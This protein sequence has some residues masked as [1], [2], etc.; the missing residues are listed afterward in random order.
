[1]SHGEPRPQSEPRGRTRVEAVSVARALDEIIERR[2]LQR[3]YALYREIAR[4][5]GVHPTTVLRYH[6]GRLSTARGI[7]RARTLAL[8]QEVRHGRRLPFESRKPRRQ[9][10]ARIAADARIPTDELKETFEVVRRALGLRQH[11]FL[12]R[13]LA[14]RLG[15]H[16]TTIMR[17]VTGELQT[18]P[19]KLFD[20][21]NGLRERI[22]DGDQVGFT[23]SEDGLPVVLRERTVELLRRL[24]GE[25]DD[26]CIAEV[27][28]KIEARLELKQGVLAR[29]Y[30]DRKLSFVLADVHRALEQ[31]VDG[32]EYDA[33]AVYRIGDRLCHHLFGLGLVREKVHKDK[34]LVEFVDGR[35]VLLSEAVPEDPYAYVQGKGSPDPGVPQCTWGSRS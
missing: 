29:I 26:R 15:V 34:I 8:L 23:R 14:E 22:A 24:L 7:V 13:Y 33:S 30:Y 9:R 2:Q 25:Q 32:V 6:Q 31:Y 4:D 21:L 10:R 5:T 3:P 16:S 19:A 1:M 20:E 18:A 27:F 12:Y 28:R 35:Q 11:Q 17:Y